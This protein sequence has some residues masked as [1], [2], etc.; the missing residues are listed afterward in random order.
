MD[1]RLRKQLICRRMSRGTWRSRTK[2]VASVVAVLLSSS[3]ALS[4]PS[5]PHELG[6]GVTTAIGLAPS[7]A[8]GE[9]SGQFIPATLLG[10]R[11][12]YGLH[13]GSGLR[14]GV[15]ASVVRTF[16]ELKGSAEGRS[17]GAW[18]AVPAGWIA[19]RSIGERFEAGGRLAIGYGVGGSLESDL[20]RN[21]VPAG[22]FE[23]AAEL[24]WRSPDLFV[25]FG[26]LSTGVKDVERAGLA[27]LGLT[28]GGRL[29]L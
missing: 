4:L 25:R 8:R 14:V 16:Y 27:G 10:L 2:Q 26:L 28:F 15:E 21:A 12:E 18:C 20:S 9:D 1:A 7:Q 6:A 5:T 13:V 17:G 23:L 11:L 3:T 29:R 19:V 22:L 24:A